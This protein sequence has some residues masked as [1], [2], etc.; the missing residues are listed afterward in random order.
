MG[1]IGFIS[2]NAA[3]QA[4]KAQG[5]VGLTGSGQQCFPVQF[6]DGSWGY[7]TAHTVFRFDIPGEVIIPGG[8]IP[9][10]I[11]DAWSKGFASWEDVE[12]SIQKEEK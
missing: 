4:A 10:K 11:W 2:E 9:G 3:F 1:K 12:K 7:W 6:P 5:E 8:S